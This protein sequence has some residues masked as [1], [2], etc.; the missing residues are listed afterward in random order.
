MAI[1][2][3]RAVEEM[4]NMLD[5]INS[6]VWVELEDD[7]SM[8]CMMTERKGELMIHFKDKTDTYRRGFVLKS[9]YEVDY[10]KEGLI[11]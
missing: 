3:V 10:G 1:G 11:R 6:G 8:L 9:E 2:I 7:R 4:E 5:H